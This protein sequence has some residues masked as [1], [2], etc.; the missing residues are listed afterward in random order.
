M[1]KKTKAIYKD[2]AALCTTMNNVRRWNIAGNCIIVRKSV[3]F[4][5]HVMCF[6]SCAR[7]KTSKATLCSTYFLFALAKWY[8]HHSMGYR[9]GNAISLFSWNQAKNTTLLLIAGHDLLFVATESILIPTGFLYT[10]RSQ[11]VPPESKR[12]AHRDYCVVC[13]LGCNSSLNSHMIMEWCS[14]LD[15]A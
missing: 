4:W 9:F 2:N 12:H 6:K 5:P 13:P 14:K 10:H 8:M 1:A 11:I 15:V 7:P 3:L